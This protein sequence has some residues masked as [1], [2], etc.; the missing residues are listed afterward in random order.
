MLYLE[1]PTGFAEWTDQALNGAI[2][3]RSIERHWSDEEL[4]TLG[5]YRVLDPGVPEGFRELSREIALVGGVV[6]FVYKTEPIPPR[7][8][9]D[10]QLT[11]RQVRR[12]IANS[13]GLDAVT[14]AID[15]LPAGPV[16]DLARVDWDDSPVYLRSHPLFDQLAVSVGVTPAEIDALWMWG[17]SFDP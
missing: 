13:V 5:L 8:P 16:R 2:Y 14:A 15:A 7:A 1:T 10:V 11:R 3:P 4:L 12:V 17:E 6:Q 9:A